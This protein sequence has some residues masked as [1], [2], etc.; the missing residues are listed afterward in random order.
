V[1]SALPGQVSKTPESGEFVARGSFIVRGERTWYRNI[2]LA[3]A[4]GLMLEPHAAVIGGPPSAIR[5]KARVSIELRPGQFEPNDT[6]KK[7]LRILK[8]K[9]G[10]DEA[11]SLKGILNTESV[12]AFVPPG[13][14]DIVGQP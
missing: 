4:V 9:I 6:A 5:E 10:E 12:A 3:A 2:P 11:K 1:F 14:S 7:A 8:E 13:G